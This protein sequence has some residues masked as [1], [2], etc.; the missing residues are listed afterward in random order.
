LWLSVIIQ[1]M[2]V[3]ILSLLLILALG[4]N[5]DI[6]STSACTN[7]ANGFCT[8]WEQNGTVQEQLGSCFPGS[9]R[10]MTTDGP[11]SMRELKK[12]DM[13]LGWVDGK[14]EYVRVTSWYHRLPEK[15]EEYLQL[16]TGN[17]W[18]QVSAKHNL[19]S[20]TREYRFAEEAES[21]FPEGHI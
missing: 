14:E 5:F 6:V 12:G 3:V 11:R 21:L 19:A 10:V 4:S 9:A 16:Q 20:R 1:I 15:S 2:K 17:G 7:T 13:I 18:M 8:R